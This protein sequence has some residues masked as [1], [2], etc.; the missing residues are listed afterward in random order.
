MRV[1]DF[2]K[3]FI[4]GVIFSA[5]VFGFLVGAVVQ[6]ERGREIVEYVE[7]M[8][9]IEVLR[10]DYVN[11]DPVEFFGVPGVRGAADGAAA[12]FEQRRDEILQRFRSRFAD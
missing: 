10:E 5:I 2:G 1:F 6:R 8:Q 9:V 12:D 4:A 3:G 11:R 7:R